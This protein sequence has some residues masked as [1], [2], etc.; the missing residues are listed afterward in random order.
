MQSAT[1]RQHLHALDSALIGTNMQVLDDLYDQWQHDP[2]SVEPSLAEY[3]QKIATQPL[4]E[5]VLQNE[6][7]PVS[8][9]NGKVVMKQS[10]VQSSRIAWMIRAWEVRGHLLADLDPLAL[11]AVQAGDSKMGALRDPKFKWGK[12]P[13]LEAHMFGFTEH[14]MHSTYQIGFSDNV[15][16]LLSTSTPPMTVAELYQR[17]EKTYAGHI[18]WEFMH[19]ADAE[20]TSWLRS[21]IETP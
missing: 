4:E 12:P 8:E 20:R 11:H 15:G 19:I 1:P 17:L 9:V 10:L 7:R 14:D 2:D 18:G 13:E 16:G 6:I 3:F 5:P 21:R